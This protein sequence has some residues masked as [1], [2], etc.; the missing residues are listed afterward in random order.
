MSD[1]GFVTETPAVKGFTSRELWTWAAGEAM[2]DAGLT[3]GDIDALVIG[4]MVGELA[5][6]QYHMANL[7]AQWTG[8]KSSE[9]VWK[10]AV[11]IE[12][13]C[14]SSSHAIRQAAFA[15]ASGV[16]DVVITGGA[17]VNNAKVDWLAPGQPRRMTNDERLRAVYC[18]YD[19][20]WELPQ[21]IVQDQALSQW[22]IAYAHRYGLSLDQLYDV[23][24]ARI[25]S[26]YHNGQSN[27]RAFWRLSLKEAA[28]QKGFADPHDFLR[29]PEVNP[30]ACWPSRLWDG[31]RRC[32]GA[33]AV[34]LCA[35]D[36]AKGLPR[37]P[38]Y[39][40]GT[41]NANSTMLSEPMYTQPFIVEAGRQAFEM[42]GVTPAEVDIAEVYDFAAAEY[43]VPLEDL[44]Y[45]APGEAAHSL[46]AGQT[47]L[48]GRKPVNASGGTTAGLVVG[49]VGAIEIYHMVRQLRGEA[50]PNQVRKPAKIGVVYD[51]GAARDAVIHVLGS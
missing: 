4:N 3:P 2:S 44:G 34:I 16:Y 23:L 25:A 33:A 20:A 5:E 22:L 14:A 35:A 42:A 10:P 45:F 37:K 43:L 50:G 1:L 27:Q 28:S 8:L 49:A 17:E 9:S 6:D 18:H 15:I 21:M 32:D 24:D 39:Y 29:S 48:A 47:T 41:G 13:A 11:R 46:V 51:C 26:N 30:V 36:L 19:Q 7:L 40:M 12:G 31:P 38:I